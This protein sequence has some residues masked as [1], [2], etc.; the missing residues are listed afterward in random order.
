[1]PDEHRCADC[2]QPVTDQHAGSVAINGR[3]RHHLMHVCIA[4]LG[5]AVK[6]LEDAARLQDG[7]Q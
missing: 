7:E 5:A 1:M 6:R 4:A 3:A 2:G